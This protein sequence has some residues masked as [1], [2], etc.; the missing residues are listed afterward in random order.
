MT[1][2]AEYAA[3]DRRGIVRLLN[4]A[5]GRALCLAGAIDAASVDSFRRRYGREPIEVDVIDTASVTELSAE[6]AELLREH[7]AAA[8]RSGRRVLVR[9]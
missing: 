5:A 9:G 2:V 1:S 4:T 7:L 6:G 3:A 8:E